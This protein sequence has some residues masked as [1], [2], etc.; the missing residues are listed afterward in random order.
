MKVLITVDPEIPVPPMHYGGIERM[1]AFLVD[2]L[3]ARG[4]GVTLIAHPGSRTGAELHPWPGARSQ[5]AGD[6]ARNILHCR[7]VFRNAGPFD[8]IHSFARMAYLL[9]LLPLGTPKIQSYQRHVNRRSV[10]WA[11]RIGGRSMIFTA[12]SR[13]IMERAR[14]GDERWEAIPNGVVLAKYRFA[15][16]VAA[17]APLVFLGRLERI[18]GAHH[19]IAT[20]RRA[21]RRLVLAG[22]RAD[23]GPEAEYF[24]RE[25]APH[26]DGERVRYV[27]PVDDEAKNR[28][29]GEAAALLFPIEWEEPFGI[30]MI[31]AMACGTPVVAL[32]RGA[33]PEVVEHGVTGWVASSV[34]GL[35]EG[36][37]RAGE[38]RRRDCRQRAERE[39][40]S[41][42]IANRY[43]DVYREAQGAPPDFSNTLSGEKIGPG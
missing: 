6:L 39:F 37:R 1:V 43:L 2:E 25:I 40:A 29:L 10:R 17:D 11:S 15:E 35:G 24:E 3:R 42:L 32:G 41:D 33:V 5:N 31:E 12:C 8:V 28:L 14:V 21:G 22:N 19:A 13:F 26:V 23:A 30:V 18:K 20:A 36:V 4:V 27:G 38:F 7:R 16:S 34:E 9:P